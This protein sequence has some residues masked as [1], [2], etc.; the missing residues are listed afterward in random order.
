METSQQPSR[1]ADRMTQPTQEQENL[2]SKY[3]NESTPVVECKAAGPTLVDGAQKVYT[4][5]RTSTFYSS[6]RAVT[7]ASHSA[8]D[9]SEKSFYKFQIKNPPQKKFLS[10]YL[11]E[12]GLQRLL[13]KRHDQLE[14]VLLPP[15][16]CEVEGLAAVI[17]WMQDAV[18]MSFSRRNGIKFPSSSVLKACYIERALRA[19]GLTTDADDFRQKI[20]LDYFFDQDLSVSDMRK[21]WTNLPYDSFWVKYMRQA[22]IRLIKAHH[23]GPPPP[24]EQFR[25]LLKFIAG[26]TSFQSYLEICVGRRLSPKFKRDPTIERWVMQAADREVVN[27]ENVEYETIKLEGYMKPF[28]FEWVERDGKVGGGVFIQS[29]IKWKD[30]ELF[31]MVHRR[32]I[33]YETSVGREWLESRRRNADED[34]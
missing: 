14:V 34:D 8:A 21:I 31:P 12:P 6:E 23:H 15:L 4:A 2:Q 26:S 7:F 16:S 33:R 10:F 19:L 18:H 1:Y 13:A 5:F 29:G 25:E 3:S 17:A 20:I 9:A 30:R 11:T 28:S 27:D 24:Q 32:R 22:A